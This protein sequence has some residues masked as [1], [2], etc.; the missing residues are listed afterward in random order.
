M[1]RFSASQKPGIDIPVIERIM[2]N[3]SIGPFLCVAA[4][5]PSGTPI[6]RQIVIA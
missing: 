4:V 6:S 5:M 2:Q 1:M 3:L